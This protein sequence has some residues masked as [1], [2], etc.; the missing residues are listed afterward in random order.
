MQGL[1]RAGP[2]DNR[3]GRQR[4]TRFLGAIVDGIYSVLVSGQSKRVPFDYA[5]IRRLGAHDC[6]IASSFQHAAYV[7]W[8][9]CGCGCECGGRRVLV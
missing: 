4:G 5:C 7:S 6:V 9:G 8:P 2:L 3:G 1:A